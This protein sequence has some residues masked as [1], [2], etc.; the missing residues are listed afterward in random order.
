MVG[1]EHACP[2][3]GVGEACEHACARNV[4]STQLVVWRRW[5]DG[6]VEG[7]TE[8]WTG[9]RK[10]GQLDGEVDGWMDGWMDS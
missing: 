3:A 2:R 4:M 8:G 7:W 9:R 10:D 5:V 6:Q 1:W